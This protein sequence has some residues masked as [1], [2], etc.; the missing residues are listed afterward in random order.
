[1]FAPVFEK[2]A[3][4]YPDAIFAKVDTDAE[5]R[6]AA[7]FNI[8]SIPTLAAIRNNTVVFMQPG[9]L[10]ASSLKT[11]VDE[12]IKL[13]ESQIGAGKPGI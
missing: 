3:E 13:D 8:N 5:Q 4:E 6:I 7:A 10:P 11:V 9:A 1:M 12:V 2:T